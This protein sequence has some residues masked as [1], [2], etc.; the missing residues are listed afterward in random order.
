MVPESSAEWVH[1]VWIK[2][3]EIHKF[4]SFITCEILTQSYGTS[5]GSESA[6]YRSAY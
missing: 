2:V 4:Q 5:L 3:S 1:F 6:A